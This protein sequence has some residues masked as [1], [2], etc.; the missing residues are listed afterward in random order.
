MTQQE[1]DRQVR[2]R[3][4]G[5]QTPLDMKRRPL[6]MALYQGF[7]FERTTGFEPATLTLARCWNPCIQY[8]SVRL[9]GLR[10]FRRPGSAA[11]SAR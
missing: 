6:K 9:D 4:A 2:H 11:E 10:P 1:A 3:L 8:C 7:H 5:F